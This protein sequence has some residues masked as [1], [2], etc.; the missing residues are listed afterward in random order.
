MAVAR[1]AL[2][3]KC[4]EKFTSFNTDMRPDIC[5][6]CIGKIKKMEQSHID[7]IPILLKPL[8]EAEEKAEGLSYIEICKIL[9]EWDK[10]RS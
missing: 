3:T 10:A 7:A 6:D 4:K 2:C 1:I 9:R 5:G 8:I